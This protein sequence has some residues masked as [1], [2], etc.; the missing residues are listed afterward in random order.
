MN[1]PAAVLWDMDGTLVDTEPFW[2][3]AETQLVESY[4]GV[5]GHADGL[6]L[7]GKSL[8][9]SARILQAAGV[10]LEV[11][12]IVNRLT[13]D[14][15]KLLRTE[16][17]TFRP[18]AVTLLAQLRDAGIPTGMVTM[19]LRRMAH[20]VAEALAPHVF[21]VI[22]A[23]DTA[24]KPK[25]NPDPY[26]QAANA[27][28]VNIARCVVIEDSPSGLRAGVSSGAVTVGVTN[29]V[30]L[31]GYEAHAIWPSLAGRTLLDFATLI[32]DSNSVRTKP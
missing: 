13:D 6:A 30:D 11:E 32:D 2:M 7:V 22:V 5:W 14:V 12:A 8:P 10:N 25:P 15:T 4:G 28:G 16:K 27:L 3:Q 19:S 9:D 29:L 26:L 18:G 23:G 21:D 1:T 17:P 20:S 24:L 31:A